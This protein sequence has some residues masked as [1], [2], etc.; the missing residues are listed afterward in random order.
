MKIYENDGSLSYD[1]CFIYKGYIGYFE[2]LPTVGIIKGKAS[3][4]KESNVSHFSFVGGT[5]QEAYNNFKL[6]VDERLSWKNR[7]KK[8]E[9]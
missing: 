6:I 9:I 4:P 1:K 8:E 2:L 5:R 7:Y 3:N